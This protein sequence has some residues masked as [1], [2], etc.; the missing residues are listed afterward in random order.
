MGGSAFDDSEGVDHRDIQ[1]GKP[2]ASY[3]GT[4]GSAQTGA[5]TASADVGGVYTAGDHRVRGRPWPRSVRVWHR[6]RQSN[7]FVALYRDRIKKAK[8]NGSFFNIK[9]AMVNFILTF[10]TYVDA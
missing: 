3:P 6:P 5:E 10:D 8:P 2:S 9:F 1:L 7:D 4:P